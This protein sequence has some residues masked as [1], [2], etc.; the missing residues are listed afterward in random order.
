MPTGDGA[1]LRRHPLTFLMEAA[2]DTAYCQSDIEDALEK[3]IVTEEMFF[4]E[5][6]DA[7]GSI[8]R[9]LQ[10]TPGLPPLWMAT[11]MSMFVGVEG[12]PEPEKWWGQRRKTWQEDY[13]SGRRSRNSYFVSFKV[14]LSN[15]L[16]QQAARTYVDRHDDIL[17]GSMTCGL[18]ETGKANEV[19]NFLKGFSRRHIFSS[20]EAVNIELSGYRIIQE[21]LDGF[22]PLLDLPPEEFTQLRTGKASPKDYPL[23]HRLLTL[24]PNKHECAYREHMG[25]H[26]E[27][28]KEEER[29][30]KELLE[31]IYRAH[32]LVD[33]VSGMTDSHAVKVHSMLKG[34][35]VG[36]L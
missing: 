9:S 32:W 31:P 34:I 11:T 15:W 35:T 16:V 13:E 22:M 27:D 10:E 29:R 7:C 36:G 3:G 26:L 2:D 30:S 4:E 20:P 19:L 18:L 24:W 25:E 33:Y 28:G 8:L 12:E 6:R 21:I 23:T 5:L 17:S 1:E 14:A